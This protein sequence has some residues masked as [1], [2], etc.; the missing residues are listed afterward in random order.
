MK[1]KLSAALVLAITSSLAGG[2][3]L[4]SVV[5]AQADIIF[6]FTFQGD[7]GSP[8]T[9]KGEVDLPD[10]A[11]NGQPTAALHVFI[12]SATISFPFTLPF[13]TISAP[14][15]N[16]NSFTLT[17]G[18][19]T[20]YAYLADDLPTYAL[21]FNGASAILQTFGIGIENA[22][23]PA[24]TFTPVTSVGVPGPIAGAGLPGLILAGTGLLGWWRRRKKIA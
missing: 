17:N 4:C 12:D 15:I 10:S 14:I 6:D 2:M 21:S 8:G 11:T 5:P 3:A 24:T 18:S 9:V 13:D 16:S 1:S 19:I 7:S 22:T 23:G 20:A